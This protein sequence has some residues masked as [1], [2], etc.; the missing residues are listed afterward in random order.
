LRE[1]G[2]IDEAVVW[3]ER[4]AAGGNQ[5]VRHAAHEALQGL[6]AST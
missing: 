4:A 5:S 1:T 3:F 6:A 2:R